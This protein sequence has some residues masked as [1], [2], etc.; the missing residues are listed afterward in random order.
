MDRRK[1]IS[2][3][4]FTIGSGFSLSLISNPA[5]SALINIESIGGLPENWNKPDIYLNFS[6]FEI[7][8]NN[9]NDSQDFSITFKAGLDENNLSK[10]TETV[11]RPVDDGNGTNYLS[12]NLPKI[13]L[14]N[15]K[16]VNIDTDLSKEETINIFFQVKITVDEVIF[17]TNIE[18]IL[19]D[20]IPPVQTVD[21]FENQQRDG[22]LPENNARIVQNSYHGTYALDSRDSSSSDRVY[23]D[24]EGPLT[25]QGSYEISG[26]WYPN[27]PKWSVYLELVNLNNSSEVIKIVN[28]SDEIKLNAKD[29]SI[30]NSDSINKS[31]INDW[32][33][34]KFQIKDNT[35]RFRHWP[36]VNSEPN[37][38]DLQVDVPSNFDIWFRPSPGVVGI[39][40][41]K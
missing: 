13:N 2:T 40:I 39:Q 22:W 29:S 17:E 35:V 34:W 5:I 3:S 8:T 26:T 27:V 15:S 9:I 10:V 36:A 1:F 6:K 20:I 4:I 11:Y 21:N 33:S 14:T 37:T 32:F 7:I 18:K 25:S 16:N 28:S 31:E 19:I 41:E 12:D 24:S 23:W 30:S 38:W